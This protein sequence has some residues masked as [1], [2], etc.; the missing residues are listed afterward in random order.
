MIETTI[1]QTLETSTPVAALVGKRIR[2]VILGIKEPMPYVIYSI[3]DMAPAT[4]D[5]WKSY[6]VELS[7]VAETYTDAVLLSG[8][9]LDEFP[10]CPVLSYESGA[11]LIGEGGS[12]AIAYR[13][14][15]AI[16]VIEES[17]VAGRSVFAFYDPG[18]FDE[19]DTP[20]Y[21][22]V[23]GVKDITNPLVARDVIDR[24]ATTGYRKTGLG[25]YVKSEENQLEI[26]LIS[27]TTTPDFAALVASK[28]E[29]QSRVKVAGK[30][31]SF[32]AII[33]SVEFV[34]VPNT[35]DEIIM[36]IHPQSQIGVS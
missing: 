30:T 35:K 11:I 26:T 36:K 23:F 34:K 1:R 6:Q 10:D 18:D 16:E 33:G 15:A 7:S 24:S 17:N 22:E 19:G 2:P 4:I 8:K 31:L 13:V 9:V 5:G 14:D 12:D 21:T 28:T 29:I 25:D 32:T 27:S 3:S 20:A